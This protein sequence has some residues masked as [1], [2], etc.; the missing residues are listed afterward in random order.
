M[1]PRILEARE[2]YSTYNGMAQEG[3]YYRV[4]ALLDSIERIYKQ[5]DHYRNSFELG[6]LDNNRAAALLTLALHSETIAPA[7]HPFPGISSDSLVNLAEVHVNRAIRTYT[8]WH[9]LYASKS[10]RQI[11]QTIEKEFL[12]GLEQAE[13]GLRSKYLEARVDEIKVAVMENDRRLSVCFTNL[14]LVHRHMGDNES[15]VKQYEKAIELWDRNL[16]AENN[17]NRLLNRPLKKRNLIQK[18]FPPGR[19]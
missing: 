18:L 11:L 15:A 19:D 10:S 6:V 8:E 12:E 14:G 1:D 7:A 9:D 4:F 16:E 5:H 2:L 3:D 17:L 13:P